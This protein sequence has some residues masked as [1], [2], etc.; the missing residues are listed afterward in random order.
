MERRLG[1]PPKSLAQLIARRGRAARSGWP[2]AEP[3]ADALGQFGLLFEETVSSP[4]D[5]LGGVAGGD[6]GVETHVRESGHGAHGHGFDGNLAGVENRVVTHVS[7][8]RP[9]LPAVVEAGASDARD[10]VPAAEVGAARKLWGV[11]ELVGVLRGRLEREYGDVWVE[12]EISNFRPYAGSGALYF[13]LK[14]G[15]AQLPAVLFRRQAGLLK[16]KPAEGMAVLARGRVSMYESR[17]QLQLIAET[18]EPRGAGAL[19]VQFEQLKARLREEGLFDAGRKRALPAYPGTIGVVT[20]TAGAVIRDIVTVCRRRHGCLNIL[21]YPA[22]V[23]GVGAAAEVSAGVRYFNRVVAGRQRVDL[24]VVA[25]GGGSVEDLWAFNDEGLARAI[26]ASELPVV[27]AVGHEMDFTIAD[28]VADLRAATPSAAAEMVTEAAH[29]A[30]ERVEALRARLL[31]GVRWQAMLARQ[32]WVRVGAERALLR[33]PEAVE[34]RAQRVDDLRDALV[35]AMERRVR[36]AAE[37]VLGLRARVLRQDAGVAVAVSRVRLV[38]VQTRLER[39][40]ERQ[41]VP[42]RGAVERAAAR[43]RALSPVAVLE[44]GYALAFAEDG[45]LLRSTGQVGVGST[46]RV[47]VADGVVRTRVEEKTG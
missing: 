1:A 22:A 17:G 39:A 5:E 8:T 6:D 46:V 33:V 38:E 9:G 47:Q 26:A 19:Q 44:R 23:Q 12:G 20:S 27:S 29:R 3:S 42:Q 37:G 30:V 21:V 24:I 43:L 14:D 18:L 36:M 32:R 41:F 4:A 25:R 45:R 31:R 15:E 40:M 13:T 7:E 10:G 34:R 2:T 28:F 16:W 11:A 35:R